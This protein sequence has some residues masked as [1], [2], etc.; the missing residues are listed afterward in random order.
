[1]SYEGRTRLAGVDATPPVHYKSTIDI[2]C[3][4]CVMKKSLS[5]AVIET[6][7]NMISL[8]KSIVIAASH[9]IG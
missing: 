1:M 2:D 4:E 6:D 7:R 9:T 5:H 3:I 8:G